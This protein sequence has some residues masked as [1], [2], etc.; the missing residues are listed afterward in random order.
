MLQDRSEAEDVTQEAM[1]RLWKIAPDWRQGEAKVSTWL[2]R[3]AKNLCLDRLRKKPSVDLDA[4]DEP[5]DET[6][7]AT[8]MLINAD[9]MKALE[10]ALGQLPERQRMAVTL[11]HIEGLFKPRHRRHS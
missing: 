6:P 5:A 3:I 2:L 9:K 11:R 4:I 8:D 10:D 1:L 7:S